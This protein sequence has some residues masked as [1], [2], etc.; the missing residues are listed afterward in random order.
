MNVRADN[1]GGRLDRL[2]RLGLPGV[3]QAQAEVRP[4]QK[5]STKL[6]LPKGACAFA[7]Q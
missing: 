7:E 1:R 6:F 2:G 4:G 5:S 3:L